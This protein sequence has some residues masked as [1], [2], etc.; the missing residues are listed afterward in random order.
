M[1]RF[2]V[3]ETSLQQ[4]QVVERKRIADQRGFFS[5][6]FC[7]EDLAAAG[8]LKPIAQVNHALTRQRGTV[9]GLHFQR[10]PR[11]EMK[12]VTC[13]RGAVFDVAVDVRATSETY[14]RWH[15][16]ELSAENGRAL[17]IPEGHAH[18]F[19]ALTDDVELLYLHSEAYSAPDEGGLN[20]T[21]AKIAISWPLPVSLLSERDAALPMTTAF[22]GE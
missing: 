6:V 10:A 22:R 19:Q 17:L 7:A 16:E 3:F 11:A 18:G 1:N 5:R 12:L 4:V 14:L 13:I 15:G 20:P 21:D 2:S 8:W 9:R